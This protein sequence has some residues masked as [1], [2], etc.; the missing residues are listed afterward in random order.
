MRLF[1]LSSLA[2]LVA[3]SPAQGVPTPGQIGPGDPAKAKNVTADAGRARQLLQLGMG[4]QAIYNVR[5][6]I[7]QRDSGSDV[8]QQIKVEMSKAGKIHQIVLAPLSIQGT[9]LV[10]DGVVTL[11]YT[12][13]DRSVL[14]QPSA[15]MDVDDVRFRMK[16][17]ERNYT[18][19]IDR[20][21]KVAG[22]A[23][24]VVQAM[25]KNDDLEM[26]CYSIDEKTG[27]LLRLETCKEG[28][29]PVMHF[30]AKMVDYP[31]EFPEN[32][33]RL[34]ASIGVRVKRVESQC[35]SP[36]S[37]NKLR[38]DLHFQPV[39]PDNLPYGFAV[40]ELQSSSGSGVPALAVRV[41]DGLAKATVL[42]WRS[43]HAQRSSFPGTISANTG[44]LTL[45][46]S[47]D[48]PEDVKDRI[49]R[50]FVKAAREQSLI[51]P[52]LALAQDPELR[53]NSD[54]FQIDRATVESTERYFVIP[55][56]IRI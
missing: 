44:K 32:T 4:R 56:L 28:A 3:L 36:T 19:R 38:E 13:D 26:R 49:L 54:M 12:P 24:L 48:I 37:G 27:F 39:V 46:I 50:A 33:F 17:V 21:E 9:E 41:T 23:A 42:E 35:V 47:G 43:T 34:D 20:K 40:Q 6:I 30:E 18:L 22:R 1:V 52:V 31:A 10:D 25:P 16:L 15:K 53:C 45:L 2:I 51:Q 11:T 8:L 5:A 7:V 14:Q 55:L 29:A